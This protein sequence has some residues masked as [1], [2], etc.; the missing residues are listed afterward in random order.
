MLAAHVVASVTLLGMISCDPKG[1][2]LS[3]VVDLS[4]VEAAVNAMRSFVESPSA[5]IAVCQSL[6]NMCQHAEGAVAVVSR[7]VSRQINRMLQDVAANT[8]ASLQWGQQLSDVLEHMLAVVDVCADVA[9]S[10]ETL[11]KQGIVQVVVSVLDN[12][13]VGEGNTQD[14]GATGTAD[15]F[16]EVR[17]LITSILSKLL[18]MA[19]VG[20]ANNAVQETCARM[21]AGVAEGTGGGLS[22][23]ALSVGVAGLN[24]LAALC[25]VPVGRNGGHELWRSAAK[26]DVAS[27]LPLAPESCDPSYSVCCCVSEMCWTG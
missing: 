4:G 21:R 23:T 20:E 10:A 5:L 12:S 24:K 6:L 1:T 2:G 18:N 3:I 26:Y 17:R 15:K 22:R 16:E 13:S 19:E 11:K 9:E 7:G 25:E 14:H 8:G 27:W